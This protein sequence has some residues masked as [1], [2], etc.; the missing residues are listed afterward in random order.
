MRGLL[1]AL[2]ATVLAAGCAAS[3][4]TPNTSPVE[5]AGTPT[6]EPS[7]SASPS[8]AATTGPS[9]SSGFALAGTWHRDQSCKETARLFESLGLKALGASYITGNG[10]RSESTA[11]VAADTDMCRGASWPKTRTL[12][13]GPDGHWT[14]T[15]EG[16]QVDDG[17]PSILDD[18]AIV[19]HGDPGDP[20][21][22][23]VYHVDGGVATFTVQTPQ[24][25]TDKSC[26]EQVAWAKETFGLGPWTHG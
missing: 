26:V 23:V 15:L 9:P 18:Q 19:V 17:T 2:A 11:T 25:C 4:S 1:I 13:F 10:F 7:M 16:Q 21:V 22:T 20:D 24:P 14:G 12:T 6:A 3:Q 5:A 8:D